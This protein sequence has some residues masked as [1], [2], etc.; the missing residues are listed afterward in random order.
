LDLTRVIAGPVATRTLAWLG[1]EVLRVD[2]PGLPEIEAQHLDTGAGKRTTSVDGREAGQVLRGLIARADVV[3][4]GYRPGALSHLGLD[5]EALLERHPGLIVASLCA[6]GFDGP[7]SGRRGFDS[8]VQSATGIGYVEGLAG[9][10]GGTSILPQRLNPAGFERPGAL[11][12]Q[13]LDHA[14]GYLLA[15]AVLGAAHRGGGYEIRLSLAKTAQWLLD[16]QTPPD[17]QAIATP[18]D[19]S[20][21]MVDRQ[22]YAGIVRSPLPAIELPGVAPQDFPHPPRP[23]GK[24]SPEWT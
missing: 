23:L 12:A 6:W 9:P 8:I 10:P 5:A 22:T 7:W 21:F 2:P 20:R 16:N 13:A 15:A 1:H 17:P 18:P 24:D 4:L 14:T 11:A 19:P 3:V